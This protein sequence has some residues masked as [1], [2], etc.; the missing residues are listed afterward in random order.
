LGKKAAAMYTRFEER[1]NG[2][3]DYSAI[4]KSIGE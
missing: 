1:G 4:I 3:F 2:G